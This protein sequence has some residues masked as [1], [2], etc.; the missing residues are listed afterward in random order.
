[1]SLLLAA[2][3]LMIGSISAEAQW[4]DR[5]TP[6]IPRTRDGKPD[7]TAPAPRGPDGQPDLTGIWN[8]PDPVLSPDPMN[9]HEW[10]RA[11]ARR[12]QQNYYRMRPYY[13]CLPSGPEAARF[14]AW[15]RIIQ[16]PAAVAILNDNLTY[17]VIHLD[18]R[19][20]EGSPAPSW[21]GYSV[22]RWDRDTLV[23]DSV[24]FNDK[25][26]LAAG[27]QH[28]EALRVTERYRRPDFGHLEVEVTYTDPGAYVKAWGFTAQMALAA[29]TEML[30]S[31]CERSSQDWAGSRSDA[32]RTAVTVPPDALAGYVGVYKGVWAGRPRTVE[33][34][35]SSS[36]LVAKISVD[37]MP[38]GEPR[39]LV[40]Q[41][42][43]LF[44]G[45]GLG[46]QFILDDRGIAT[47]VVEIHIS[48]PYRF[49]R[50]P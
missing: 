1:M 5:P 26:W 46:Y 42:Q 16:T 6:G 29:D 43:T 44:E 36:Q 10:V 12:H 32:A 18:G 45:G 31:V 30:E 47:D 25:T 7:L 20:L 39:P 38:A 22:G 3:I 13:Q 50:Q 15:R 9:A 37:G 2:L 4:L 8:G 19:E 28:T 33:V 24:G 11:A 41:S 17:R 21:M 40:P 34:S 23:V 27:L 49:P 48:G 14:A 35:L